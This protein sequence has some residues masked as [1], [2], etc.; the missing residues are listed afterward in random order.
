MKIYNQWK[1][2]TCMN[3]AYIL[4]CNKLWIDVDVEKVTKINAFT[5]PRA[6]R[7][8]QEAWYIKSIVTLPRPWLVDIWLRKWH[9]IVTWTWQWDFKKA[10]VPPYIMGQWWPSNHAFCIIEDMGDKWKCQ[11]SWGEGWWDKWCFYILKS[12]FRNFRTPRRL[13]IT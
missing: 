2:W 7:L 10:A 3:Y 13:V 8:F 12:E 5:H 1:N 9:Y 4:A 11:N 6:E